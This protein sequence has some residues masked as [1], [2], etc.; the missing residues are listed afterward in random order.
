MDDPICN[1]FTIKLSHKCSYETTKQVTCVRGKRRETGLNGVECREGGVGLLYEEQACIQAGYR[2]YLSDFPIVFI[3]GVFRAMEKMVEDLEGW[4][5][6]FPILSRI[7]QI[8][9]KSNAPLSPFTIVF[10]DANSMEETRLIISWASELSDQAECM[11]HLGSNVKHDAQSIYDAV[12]NGKVIYTQPMDGSAEL[13]NL[14]KH[15]FPKRV[16]PAAIHLV[17]VGSRPIEPTFPKSSFKG[18]LY[19]HR[20]DTDQRGVW[21]NVT[22]EVIEFHKA[23]SNRGKVVIGAGAA[24]AAALA[25]MG[26]KTAWKH[27][28][29]DPGLNS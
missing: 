25:Y 6:D 27:S 14:I 28:S 26:A 21:D 3:S 5:K 4:K 13:S 29:T 2:G 17:P 24:G 1:A 20:E 11:L 15:T 10:P 7:T 19:V 12:N 18:E 9:L 16:L 8:V 23:M 22:L